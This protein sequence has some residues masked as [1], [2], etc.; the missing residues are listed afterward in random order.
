MGRKLLVS[1]PKHMEHRSMAYSY[2]ECKP[3]GCYTLA[4][5]TMGLR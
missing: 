3:M 5:G 2:L 4:N 1:S